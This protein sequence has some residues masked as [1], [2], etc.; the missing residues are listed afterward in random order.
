MSRKKA[1]EQ[2][3]QLTLTLGKRNPFHF[4]ASPAKNS[5]S[6]ALDRSDQLSPEAKALMKVTRQSAQTFVLAK[7]IEALETFRSA[8]A[9]LDTPLGRD[10]A[11]MSSLTNL[12]DRLDQGRIPGFYSDTR[13]VETKNHNNSFHQAMNRAATLEER[14]ALMHRIG[15]QTDTQGYYQHCLSLAEMAV[16]SLAVLHANVLPITSGLR[17]EPNPLLWFL[18]GFQPGSL[19]SE[20]KAAHIN[21][22]PL[23]YVTGVDL[24]NGFS[25]HPDLAFVLKWEADSSSPWKAFYEKQNSLREHPALQAVSSSL[26][27]NDHAGAGKPRGV[28]DLLCFQLEPFGTVQFYRAAYKARIKLAIEQALLCADYSLSGGGI[29]NLKGMGLGAFGIEAI[30]GELEALYI[31]ALKEVLTEHRFS[32]IQAIHLLNFPSILNTLAN[33]PKDIE[34]WTKTRATL[35]SPAIDMSKTLNPTLPLRYTVGPALGL[36]KGELATQ[37]NG[38]SLSLPGNEANVYD[39]EGSPL[40]PSKSSS[41]ES[42]ISFATGGLSSMLAWYELSPAEKQERTWILEEGK[43]LPL[44]NYLAE[45]NTTRFTPS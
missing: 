31:E 35:G 3:H 34:F 22:V 7:H 23:S 37:I 14:Q 24:R 44:T 40:V 38:D 39:N 6:E 27:G 17:V 36:E 45:S 30:T 8:M 16:S 21:P 20:M 25:V 28:S 13:L 42:T 12:L 41:D 1:A 9:K 4:F 43:A 11:K 15:S 2:I 5:I 10:Y 19:I 33:Q 29:V 32:R 26:Y 18:L